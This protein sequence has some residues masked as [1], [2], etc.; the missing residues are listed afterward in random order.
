MKLYFSYSKLP[1]LAGLTRRQRRAVLQC[2]LEA[3]YHEQ[4]SRAWSG[5]P[6]IFGG[7]FAGTLTGGML[8]AGTGLAH[9]F[10]MACC[11]SLCFGRSHRGRFHRRTN[12]YRTVAPVPA[13]CPRRAEG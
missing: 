6:W 4:P 8:V 7:M 9:S 5:A 3:F 2:A 12:L 11:D 1:E 10:E 13:A